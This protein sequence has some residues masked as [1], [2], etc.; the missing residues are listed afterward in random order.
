MTKTQAIKETTQE[1]TTIY[2][3]GCQWRYN[4][5]DVKVNAWRE[6]MPNDYCNTRS[7]RKVDMIRAARMKLC[8]E[9][10]DYLKPGDYRGSQSWQY[11]V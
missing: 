8:I 5:F 3:F 10:D 1:Y 2:R 6:S 9:D 4:W 7:N 11:W